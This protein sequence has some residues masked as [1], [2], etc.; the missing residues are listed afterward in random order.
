[1]N[2]DR[3]YI[4]PIGLL[5]K[6]FSGEATHDEV[7]HVKAWIAASEENRKEYEAFSK[8]WNL[9]SSHTSPSIDIDSEWKRIDAAI[10]PSRRLYA[11]VFMIAAAILLVSTLAFL[12][13]KFSTTEVVRS[14]LSEVSDLELPDGSRI[15]LNAGSKIVYKKGFGSGHRNIRL[16]GEAFFEVKK[17]S[18]PFTIH[19]GEA[20]IEVTGTEFNVKAW[21]DNDI[22]VTVTEGSVKMF[23]RESPTSEIVLK[24]GETGTYVRNNETLVKDFGVD[25]NDMAW[26][27]LILDFRNTPLSEVTRILSNTY[28]IPITL[29]TALNRCAV[30]V[31]FE[32]QEADSVLNVLKSTLD[33][34]ITKKA[35]R[36]HISGE[37]C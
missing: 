18:I 17:N 10:T 20:G 2:S 9:T 29:D 37:G 19:A 3:Q 35:K 15:S 27:T 28:H 22:K 30:T 25:R 33:L 24:N 13:I 11:K 21:L 36:I 12:G 7:N 16:T 1:M 14:S 4:D 31:R 8:I 23:A 34:T 6:F 26:K 32:K 5:P